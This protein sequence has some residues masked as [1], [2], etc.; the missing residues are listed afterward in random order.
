MPYCSKCGNHLPEDA[1]YCD[2]CGSRIGA[3]DEVATTKPTSSLTPARIAIAA[4]VVLVLCLIV[5]LVARSC[6]SST[7]SVQ[8]TTTS[9]HAA[10]TSTSGKDSKSSGD[11]SADAAAD[12]STAAKSTTLEGDSWSLALP[13]YWTDKVTVKKESSESGT[14][15]SVY[16]IGQEKYPVVSVMV[17]DNSLEEKSTSDTVKL[18]DGMSAKIVIP[19]GISYRFSVPLGD[20]KFVAVQTPQAYAE[21][22]SNRW[23]GL[24]QEQVHQMGDLQSQGKAQYSDD[25]NDAS[26]PIGCLRELASTL[27]VEPRDGRTSDSSSAKA[28]DAQATNGNAS[29]SSSTKPAS[30]EQ[31]AINLIQGWWSSAGG[32]MSGMTSTSVC[33]EGNTITGYSYADLQGSD[34]I[35]SSRVERAHLLDKDG[36]YFHDLN[37]FLP[38]DEQDTLMYVNADGSG[39]SGTSSWGRLQDKPSYLP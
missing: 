16:P 4:A 17:T 15:Y 38:D 2:A 35:D 32:I 8:S 21:V 29:S 1:R 24:S 5:A 23:K 28:S 7:S 10:E 39:Y 6:G 14:S 25:P 31:D 37:R 12:K 36:W 27:T 34:T 11:G 18:K 33:I 20:G 3:D 26:I 30:P 13:T 9:D 19:S 22:S